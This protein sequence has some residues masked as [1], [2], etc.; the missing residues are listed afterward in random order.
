VTPDVDVIEKSGVVVVKLEL[1]V[2]VVL[3]VSVLEEELTVIVEEAESSLGL[4]MAT[5]A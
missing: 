4:L 2:G 3:V 1:L 5:T